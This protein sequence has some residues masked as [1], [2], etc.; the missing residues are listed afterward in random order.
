MRSALYSRE[1]CVFRTSGVLSNFGVIIH[2]HCSRRK[3]GEDT[4]G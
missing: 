2:S 3:W 4:R 1:N